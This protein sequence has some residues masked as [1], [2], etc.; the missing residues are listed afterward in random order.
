MFQSSAMLMQCGHQG[1]KNL[2]KVKP[3]FRVVSKFS[4]VM[5]RLLAVARAGR[6]NATRREEIIAQS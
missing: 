5:T 4:L 3:V 2:T 6:T 1:A